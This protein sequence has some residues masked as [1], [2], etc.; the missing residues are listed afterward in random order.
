MFCG[1]F[2]A[3]DDILRMTLAHRAD[4]SGTNRYRGAALMPAAECGH[5]D[6]VRMLIDVRVNVDHVNRLGWA[7]LLEAITLGDGSERDVPVERLTPLQHARR[8]GRV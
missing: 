5:V 6:T 8:R 1:V 4:L 3:F 7:A 2:D